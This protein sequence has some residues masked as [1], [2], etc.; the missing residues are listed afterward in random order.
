M[1]QN[2][3]MEDYLQNS[4]SCKGMLKDLLQS[5]EYSKANGTM[6]FPVGMSNENIYIEDLSQ[7]PSMLITGTTGSGKTSFV[8]ALI[9]SLILQYTPNELKFIIVDSKGIDYLLFKDIPH[10]MTPII[11]VPQKVCGLLN[12]LLSESKQRLSQLSTN[13][14][15][16]LERI[17]LIIDDFSLVAQYSENFECIERLLTIC[18]SVNIHCIFCTSI[19]TTKIISPIIKANI[20]C[21]V[22]FR[23]SSKQLS[24]LAI[25]E[26]G[27]ESLNIPGEAWIKTNNEYY[28]CCTAHA[29]DEETRFIVQQVNQ[30]FGTYQIKSYK[31]TTELDDGLIREAQ[32]VIAE[33]GIISPSLLQRKLKI[34]Y[35]KVSKIIELINNEQKT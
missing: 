9:N 20:S 35:E 3:I 21:K 2:R 33:A 11:S 27:A 6:V 15:L 23:A 10:L 29:S 17:V 8:Q 28:K 12:W 25:D 18:R 19:P 13:R 26:V 1:K 22:A 30:K 24:K 16:E 7:I 5:N 14:T 32:K 34:G 31:N 4:Y